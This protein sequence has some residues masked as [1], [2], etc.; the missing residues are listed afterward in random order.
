[1]RR[2]LMIIIISSAVTVAGLYWVLNSKTVTE[3]II[4]PVANLFLKDIRITDLLLAKQRFK[5][6]GSSEFDK[7]MIKLRDKT[8]EMAIAVDRLQVSSIYA[9]FS[10]DQPIKIHVQNGT[11]MGFDLVIEDI[12]YDGVLTRREEDNFEINGDLSINNATTQKLTASEISAHI[13][14]MVDDFNLSPITAVFYGGSVSATVSCKPEQQ[15]YVNLILALESVDISELAKD[16][17]DLFAQVDGIANITI[18]M[19]AA[20]GNITDIQADMVMTKDSRINAALLQFVVAYIPQSAERK[21]LALLVEHQG[22]IDLDKAIA[23]VTNIDSE[24]ITLALQ[25]AS[26]RIN[27]DLNLTLDLIVEGGFMNI[28]MLTDK[29]RQTR[30]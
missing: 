10:K 25:L 2:I 22:R 24:K 18:A 26:K 7:L 30:S 16:R 4:P 27:L 17:P 15:G 1:M 5:I 29:N 3:K 8:G 23:K 14:G 11:F 13:E 21:E 6:N 12:Q 19:E 28:L 9:L 20:E